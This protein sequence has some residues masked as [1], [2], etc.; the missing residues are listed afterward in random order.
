MMVQFK[1]WSSSSTFLTVQVTYAEMVLVVQILLPCDYWRVERINQCAY[2]S[3][4]LKKEQHLTELFGFRNVS[5]SQCYR[6][7]SQFFLPSVFSPPCFYNNFWKNITTLITRK[8]ESAI[9]FIF[10]LSC[11]QEKWSILLFKY[12]FSF[13]THFHI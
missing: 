13:K 7:K 6:H 10:L 2:H 1:P 12:S 3:V 11:H 5:W 9:H 8:E 4:L